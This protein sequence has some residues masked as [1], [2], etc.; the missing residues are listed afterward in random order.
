MRT[1]SRD[2]QEA[3]ARERSERR[4]WSCNTE[5]GAVFCTHHGDCTCRVIRPRRPR[6]VGDQLVISTGC[7]LHDP[8][9]GHPLP[10]P[11]MRSSSWA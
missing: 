9:F 1:L 8:V 4:P 3:A 2:A 10:E 5:P 6:R 7:P 11:V